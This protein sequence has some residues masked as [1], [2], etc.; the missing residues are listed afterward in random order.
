MARNT[1][2]AAMKR[3]L[4]LPHGTAG[5]VLPHLWIGR[6]MLERGHQV[7]MIWSETYREPARQA[8]LDYG[9]LPDDGYHEMMRNPSIWKPHESIRLGNAYAGRSTGAYMTA[10]MEKIRR[11][12][13]FDL[14]LAPMMVFAA[15]LLRQKLGIPLISTHVSALQLM[16]VHEVP[17]G[18]PAAGLL[19]RLP[20]PLRRFLMT[21]I[22]PYDH[23]VFPHVRRCCH[24][25]GVTP[26]RRLRDWWHSPDG[27]LALFPKW[28]APPQPDWPVRTLQWDFP[29]EDMADVTPPDP[30]LTAFLSAGDKPVVFTLGSAHLHSARYYEIAAAV[31]ARLGCRAVFVARDASQVPTALP[32]S[33]FV[34]SYAPFSALLPHAAA[35]AHHGGIGTTSQ[36]FAAGLPQLIT[37]LAYDQPDNAAQ[38]ERLGAGLRLNIDQWTVK[39]VLPLLRRCLEDADIRQKA[40]ECARRTR[41]RPPATALVEWLEAKCG[42]LADVSLP[43]PTQA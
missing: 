14:I 33:V 34:T 20:L 37:P 43:I 32:A 39:R 19:R 9:V 6:R 18:I 16:S 8:G 42:R 24:E 13:R 40:R 26:P 22:T 5:D 2:R 35:F 7:T 10:M 31:T 28:F 21:R 36:C 23:L 15:P 17:L 12:G 3:I 30:A 25:H 41:D 38:V 11:D 29:L 1:M 27:S 4:L